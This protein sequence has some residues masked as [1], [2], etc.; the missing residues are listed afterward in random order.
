VNAGSG[1]GARAGLRV[2]SNPE[3]GV[4]FEIDDSF[5]P[6]PRLELP[7]GT[8]GDVRSAYLATHDPGGAQAVLSITRVEVGY[9]TSPQELAEHLLIHNRYAAH[10]AEQNGWTIHAPWKAALLGGHPAMH[11]DYVVPDRAG[12]VAAG[13]AA[14]GDVVAGDAA[15]V[16][17]EAGGPP[18][19][20]DLP[21]AAPTQDSTA[22]HVQAWVAYAGHQTLQ[23]MLSVD[24]PGDLVRNR[25]TLE[26]VVRTFEVSAPPADDPGGET[27]RATR[28]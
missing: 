24:P 18:P 26:T 22:G 27:A 2:Y 1:S 17:G 12:D 3:L 16:A 4:R 8:P 21:L 14:A 23:L 11:C 5:V 25:A 15:S 9:D 6:G 13:G 28:G 10:T 19:T 7:A 20:P